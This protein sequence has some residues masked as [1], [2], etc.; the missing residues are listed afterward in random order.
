MLRTIGFESINN[1]VVDIQRYGNSKL[2]LLEQLA[3][4]AS[5][6]DASFAI[7]E[8]LAFLST[9]APMLHEHYFSEREEGG[10]AMSQWLRLVDRIA[11]R[12]NFTQQEYIIKLQQKKDLMHFL[13]AIFTMFVTPIALMTSYW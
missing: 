2:A 7:A 12:V 13:P 5:S 10:C 1:C 6:N 4:P 9:E 11:K 3:S 8:V